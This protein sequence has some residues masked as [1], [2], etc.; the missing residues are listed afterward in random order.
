MRQSHVYFIA[1]D[2]GYFSGFKEIGA[3][4]GPFD[5]T[6]METGAYDR[7]WPEVHMSPSQ[8]VQAHLDVQGQKMIPV[9]NGTFDLAFHSWVDPFEQ[10]DDLAKRNQV[11]LLTP[12]M[13]QVIT[14][15]NEAT[16]N[17]ARG[18]YWWRID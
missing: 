14:L 13:G 10:V 9:H 18:N 16:L 3:K 15:N 8:S 4:Y 6:M 5:L 7:D 12:K 17:Q 1:E 11:D 2:T